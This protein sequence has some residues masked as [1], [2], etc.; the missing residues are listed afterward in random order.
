M[1]MPA[2]GRTHTFEG[3]SLDSK[4]FITSQNWNG[5]TETDSLPLDC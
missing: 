1:S 3:P 2:F 5:V 4:V